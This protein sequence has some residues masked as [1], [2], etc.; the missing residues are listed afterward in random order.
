[1]DPQTLALLLSM[2][3]G[4]GMGGGMLGG[5]MGA[6]QGNALMGQG[7]P[8]GQPGGGLGGAGMGQSGAMGSGGGGNMG[9]LLQRAMLLMR[10]RQQMGQGGQPL[11]PQMLF[12]MPGQGGMPGGQMGAPGGGMPAALAMQPGAQQNPL[13]NAL[14]A[15]AAM[16]QG[17]QQPNMLAAPGY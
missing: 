13:I 5:G 15:R 9:A 6:P 4:A 17:Q 11:T 8:M 1:M 14:M 10:L 3:G 7:Q 2:N 16:G 12:G